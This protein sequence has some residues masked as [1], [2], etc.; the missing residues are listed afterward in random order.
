M[1]EWMLETDFLGGVSTYV[2]AQSDG[3]RWYTWGQVSL[4]VRGS[5]FESL[6]L[7]QFYNLANNAGQ[8]ADQHYQRGKN[9]DGYNNVDDGV[10]TRTRKSKYSTYTE[11][12]AM[13]PVWSPDGPKV[14]FEINGC[15]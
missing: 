2:G 6:T 3:T 10:T 15:W 5:E 8:S 11:G 12:H 4:T 1:R 9:N 14:A 7:I 13:N